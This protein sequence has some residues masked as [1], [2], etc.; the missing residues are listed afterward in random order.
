M[1]TDDSGTRFRSPCL[2][3]TSAGMSALATVS[4]VMDKSRTRME[5]S[6]SPGTLESV[7]STQWIRSQCRVLA[8]LTWLKLM[9][10]IGVLRVNTEF[11]EV[12]ACGVDC[13]TAYNGVHVAPVHI[14]PT[15]IQLSHYLITLLRLL[16][17][18]VDLR[19]INK[20]GFETILQPYEC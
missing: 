2:L 9:H 1:T 3:R 15:I 18:T 6:G 4:F 10:R 11:P 5:H 8:S 14:Y 13:S 12:T 7:A 16:V 20:L 19:H 17:V